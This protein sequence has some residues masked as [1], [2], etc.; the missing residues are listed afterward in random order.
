MATAM[1]CDDLVATGAKFLIARAPYDTTT[2]KFCDS[3]WSLREVMILETRTRR[4]T[5]R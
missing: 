1:I 4:P 2:L 3:P 5:E